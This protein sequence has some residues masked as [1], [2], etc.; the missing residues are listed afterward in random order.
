MVGVKMIF[1]H[2]SV[3]VGSRQ[4]DWLLRLAVAGALVGHGAYG[5]VVAKASWYSYFTVL[6]L[7]PAMV[8]AMDLLRMVGG[9]EIALGMIVLVFPI[10]AM[11]LLVAVWKIFTE[12]LRPAAGEPVW[13]FVERASNMAAALALLHFRGW[14]RSLAGWVRT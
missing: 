10:P 4:L 7:S 12:L 6:G 13:E 9:A 14:P 1:E 5:A 8:D 11:L 2:P 3:P